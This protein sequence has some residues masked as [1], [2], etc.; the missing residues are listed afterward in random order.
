MK[1]VYEKAEI[2]VFVFET[3]DVIRASSAETPAFT[4]EDT[5]LPVIR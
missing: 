1:N 3:K 4:T 2:T 5:D